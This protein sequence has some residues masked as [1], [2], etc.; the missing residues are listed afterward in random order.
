MEKINAIDFQVINEDLKQLIG[1]KINQ[2]TVI[3]SRCFLFSFSMIRNEQLF[4]SLEHQRSYLCMIPKVDSISTIVSKTNDILRKFIRDSYIVNVEQI[5]KDRIFK[6][7]LQ[8]SNELF[9]KERY[10]LIIECIPQRPNLIITDE[11]N[12]ILYAS[13]YTGLTAQRSIIQNFEYVSPAPIE[14]ILAEPKDIKTI[15]LMGAED[16]E[17]ATHK[18]AQEKYEPLFKHIKIRVKSLEKKLNVLT[19]SIEEA[20]QKRVYVDHGNMVLTLGDDIEQIKEYVKENNIKFDDS[21]SPGENANNYFKIYKKSKRTIEMNNIEIEKCKNEIS[22]LTYILSTC[23]YMDESEMYALANEILPHK[24]VQDKKHIKS[25]MIGSIQY[26]GTQICFG[27]NSTTND[28]LTFSVANKTDTFLHIKDYHGSH[29]IIRSPQVNNDTLLFAAELALILANKE[30]GEI[31]YTSVKDVKKGGKPGLVNM[32]SYKT[33]F[34]QNIR[35]ESKL[36]I[37]N[38]KNI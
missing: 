12:V 16:F 10:V 30:T 24:Y 18:R 29:I 17:N 22:Y 26:K 34:V 3:N 1:A 20:N 8:K 4:I 9:E 6:F 37:K 19:N 14:P 11:N 32:L 21:L 23:S 36:L 28:K 27:K 2:T 13:H 31:Y 5:N 25:V 15:K 38:Y 7:T 35:D 33:I